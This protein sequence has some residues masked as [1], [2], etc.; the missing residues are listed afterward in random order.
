MNQ[1]NVK[2]GPFHPEHMEQM[3]E[4]CRELV[5]AKCTIEN[6]TRNYMEIS[7]D[8]RYYIVEATV[9][10]VMAG[11]AMG[12]IITALDGNFMVVENVVVSGQ[13][14]G[15][16]IGKLILQELDR[17]AAENKCTYA[18]LVSSGFRK[19]A[20]QFYEAMGYAD[21]VRGFRKNYIS[22]K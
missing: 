7:N 1:Q 15:H 5:P 8:K 17:F 11:T 14:R 12:V 10:G 19:N 22:E 6:F 4:L 13:W 2:I 9:D 3:V 20:H 16:G 21:D 18:I